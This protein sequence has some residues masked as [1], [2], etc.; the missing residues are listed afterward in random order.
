MRHKKIEDIPT[1]V[2]TPLVKPKIQISLKC[3]FTIA[4]I[5]SLTIV[6][7]IGF[8]N[9][10]RIQER[11]FE[12]E[13]I[14]RSELVLN[15]GEASRNYVINELTPAVEK[16]TNTMIFEAKSNAFATRKI[17][18][19]FNEEIPEYIYRQPALN[20]LN[21]N[22]KADKLETEIIKYFQNNPG[23]NTTQ[24]YKTSNNQQIF[25]LAKPIKMENSYLKCHGK[26]EDAPK[27]IIEKYGTQNG[28]NWKVGE[29][30]STL[31]IYVPIQDLLH[32]QYSMV[33]VFI[34]TFIGLTI[35]LIALIYLLFDK[36]VGKRIY[37][38][39]Q[40]MNQAALNPGVTVRIRD[41]GKDE[42]GMMAKVFNKMADSL[43]DA[44][45][46]LEHKV[47]QRT[48]EIE[49]TLQEL[50]ITQSQLIQA[51]KM[52]SLG[53][54]VAGIA[55]EINNPL[56]F[57][58]G[59]INHAEKYTQELLQL[60]ALYQL[61][62]PQ[63]DNKIQN[64]INNI[65]L[66]FI[67]KDLPNLLKS[68]KIGSDRIDK[69]VVNLRNFSRLD[70][71]EMKFVD[72]HE[73]IDST[74]VIL[75]HRLKSN[76]DHPEITILKNYS[77]LPLIECNPGLLNQVFMNIISNGIDALI[78]SAENNQNSQFIPEIIIETTLI[79]SQLIQVSITDNGTGITEQV[80][81]QIFNPFFTTKP[82]GKG[83]GLGLSIS[84]KII[85]ERHQ[86]TIH[87]DSEIGKGT[88]F[89]IQLPLRI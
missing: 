60:I 56:S 11:V 4:L 79:N 17:F 82:I 43:D 25:Y 52:S 85:V 13:A 31:I 61:V 29:I 70:Q 81:S 78:T 15:F 87:C 7:S 2:F 30:I 58:S 37:Q 83:T 26:P 86:G 24:G 89:I 40:A 55:H 68:M 51:E 5:I 18:E 16:H 65:D 66:E 32:N 41:R 72:I 45:N 84:Y 12:E 59:N 74:L 39:S 48:A 53:Q 76:S 69:I 64:H 77:Q 73:G 20:P 14:N 44:Y 88:K 9:L 62:Y 19:I 22:N 1:Q 50:K 42:L 63:P 36:L 28:F 6:I 3:K 71:A 27:E 54:L 21:H 46:N 49:K 23:T 10:Y 80:K 57:I 47:A 8:L 34:Y 75:Q 33:R 35:V 67:S 38:F